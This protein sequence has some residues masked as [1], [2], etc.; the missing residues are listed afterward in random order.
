MVETVLVAIDHVDMGRKA[1]NLVMVDRTNSTNSHSSVSCPNSRFTSSLTT[2]CE[3]M[4]YNG[5][6]TSTPTFILTSPTIRRRVLDL[7]VTRS[8]GYG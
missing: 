4:T 2:R 7:C 3:T 8:G 6:T 1:L 5:Y